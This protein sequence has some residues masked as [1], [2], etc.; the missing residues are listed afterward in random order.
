MTRSEQAMVDAVNDLKVVIENQRKCLE[1]FDSLAEMV[2]NDFEKP[3]DDFAS[4]RRKSHEKMKTVN[5]NILESACDDLLGCLT[6][7]K[8]VPKKQ[9]RKKKDV[10]EFLGDLFF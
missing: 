10:L 9:K 2:E 6:T 1:Y 3:Y 7:K 8:S 4:K 5:N